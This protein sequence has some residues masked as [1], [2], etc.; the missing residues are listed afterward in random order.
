MGLR[1]RKR[2]KIR[3]G[4]SQHRADFSRTEFLARGAGNRIRLSKLSVSPLRQGATTRPLVVLNEARS[5]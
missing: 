4:D 2:A 5:T 3:G 1:P